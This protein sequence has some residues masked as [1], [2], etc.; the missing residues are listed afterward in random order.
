MQQGRAVLN[1]ELLT[2]VLAYPGGYCKL[3]HA[4]QFPDLKHQDLQIFGTP[5]VAA[6]QAKLCANLQFRQSNQYSY[7]TEL[8]LQG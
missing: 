3:G 2:Y 6:A 1:R 8:Q 5:R 4:I 7:G